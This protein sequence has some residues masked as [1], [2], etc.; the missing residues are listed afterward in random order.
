MI[1]FLTRWAGP[2]RH[3][4]TVPLSTPRLILRRFSAADTIPMFE[5]WA[6]D[7]DVTRYLTWRA[8]MTSRETRD[9]LE[10]WE[11]QY[12]KPDFY[13]WA[14]VPRDYGRPVGSIGMSKVGRLRTVMELGYCIGK[15]WWG[16]GICAEAAGAVLNLMFE[17]VGCTSIIAMHALPNENSGKVMEKCGMHRKDCPPE[18]VRTENGTFYCR[19]YEIERAEYERKS[20]GRGQDACPPVERRIYDR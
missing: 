3:C 10:Y 1:D 19:V 12:R 5:N 4:G 18:P 16:Q 13:E 7:P 11:S 15:A 8:H 6:C 17:R 9:V 14:I 20:G 2:L